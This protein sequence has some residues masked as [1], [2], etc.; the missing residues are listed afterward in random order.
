MDAAVL[1]I[2]KLAVTTAGSGHRARSVLPAR[3]DDTD[4]CAGPGPGWLLP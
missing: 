4:R 1:L 3:A 2:V